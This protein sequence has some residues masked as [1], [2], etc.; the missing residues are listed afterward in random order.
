MMEV[1]ILQR[2]GLAD[3]LLD[4]RGLTADAATPDVRAALEGRA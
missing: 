2:V 1:G 4:K 3:R